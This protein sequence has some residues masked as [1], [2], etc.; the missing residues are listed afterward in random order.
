M[1]EQFETKPDKTAIEMRAFELWSR[2]GMP[3]GRDLEYWLRAE[4]EVQRNIQA[5]G[6]NCGTTVDGRRKQARFVTGQRSYV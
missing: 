2:D 3:L 6:A 1:T 5:T 4:Q